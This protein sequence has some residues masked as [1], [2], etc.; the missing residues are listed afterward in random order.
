[1]G[2]YREAAEVVLRRQVGVYGLEMATQVANLSGYEIDSSGHV[3]SVTE[4]EK[5]FELLVENTEKYLGPLA[6]VN[7]RTALMVCSSRAT[8]MIFKAVSEVSHDV[9]LAVADL[10]TA[11]SV[12]RVPEENSGEYIKDRTPLL[13]KAERY[14]S[15]SVL[16]EKRPGSEAGFFQRVF[17]FMF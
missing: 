8:D 7:C 17:S 15:S 4:E 12:F 6:V 13:V 14:R 11:V 2:M 9:A 5:A 16:K 3:N 1:M 10:H